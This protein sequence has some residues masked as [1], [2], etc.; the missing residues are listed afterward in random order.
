[1][2][3]IKGNLISLALDGK[4]EVIIHGC[5]CFCTMGAGI[6]KAIKKNFPEAF[7]ADCRTAEGDREKLG[8]F[9]SAFIHRDN[10]ELTIIN[11]Y[12]QFHW[13]GPG[14]KVDYNALRSVMQSIK[15]NYHGK[16]IA[17][18]R[19]GAGLAGG[20]WQIIAAIIDEELDG[21]DHT[22]VILD[23]Y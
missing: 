17:Y 4:F 1:M 9:S 12:T 18:P 16:R 10:F 19:I 11:A 22:L 2:K 6:A 5:N 3:I 13:G 21:E 7:A 15:Q 8:T 14:L 20:D 23:R